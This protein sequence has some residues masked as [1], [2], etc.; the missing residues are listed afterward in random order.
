ME[1]HMAEN[2]RRVAIIGGVRTP[3]ARAWTAYDDMSAADLGSAAVRE[4]LARTEVPPAEI[5]SLV[6][7][8]VAAPHAGPNVAREIQF[9]SEIPASVPAFSVQMYC[10]SAARAILDGA[11]DIVRGDADVVVAGGAESMS[12]VRAL[13][14]ETATEVFQKAQKARSTPARLSTLAE[15]RPKDLAPQAPGLEEPSTGLSMGQSAELMAKEWGITR[16]EQDQYALDSHRKAAAATEERRLTE[17]QVPVAAPPKFDP[18]ID[19]DTDIR[20]DTSLEKLAGLRPV[21]DRK[22]GTI[23]AGNASPLTD[24]GAAVLL[25]SE[26]KAKAEGYKPLGYLRSAAMAALD[27]QREGLL[28]GPAYSTPKAL[29]RGGVTMKDIELVEMHEAFAAQML[30]LLKAFESREWAQQKLG[31]GEAI[32][33]IDPSILNVNGGSIPIGHPFGATGARLVMTLLYEMKR[34]DKGLGLATMCAAS[35]LGVSIIVEAA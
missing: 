9:R 20:P 19:R 6:F 15:L 1:E 5:D 34:R 22:Y 16:E 11:G 17:E 3:F 8:I 23:T 30:C 33:A 29:K 12:S 25:M 32:G 18:V 35:G 2:G 4:L 31:A 10:A 14:S 28:M 24:G 13:F 26:E 27:I 7:G 21:F